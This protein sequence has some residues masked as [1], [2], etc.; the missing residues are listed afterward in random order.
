MKRLELA[1]LLRAA[2]DIAGDR[3]VL[4]IGSQSIL[5][6]FDED[7]LPP[8]ATASIEADIAF[9]E[10]PDRTKADDV[11]AIIGEMSSFHQ[12]NGIYAEGVHIETAL[13][14]PPGWRERLVSWPL[15]SS[16]PAEPRF[17]E[18]HDLAVAKLGAHRPKDL[19]FVD[20]LLQARM[21]VLEELRS[22]AALLPDEHAPTRDRILGFLSSYPRGPQRSRA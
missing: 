5:G 13:Y 12:M 16:D 19:E 17:L 22:R 15:Q 4:V 2:C 6:A 9:L 21:L 3:E 7:D 11:E 10:D 8:A 20:A 1:H 14:L 18:P